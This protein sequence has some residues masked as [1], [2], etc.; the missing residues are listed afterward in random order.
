[1][2]AP[3]EPLGRKPEQPL[4]PPLGRV[5]SLHR[6]PVK[7][8]VG[9]EL[10]RVQVDERG[11][12]GDRLW[13]VRDLDG[14]FGSGKTT[15]R[16]RKMEGLLELAARY[17]AETPVV[18]FPDGRSLRG[19]DEAVHGALSEYVG[20]PV[21]LAREGGVSHFDEGPIH[22]VTT[23]TLRLLEREHGRPVQSRRLRPNLVLETADG[24]FVEEQWVDQRIRIGN[25]LVLAI[26]EPMPRCVMLDL[27][28]VG[29]PAANG[30]LKTVADLNDLNVGVVADVLTPGEVTVGDVARRESG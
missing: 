5:L 11:V 8:L 4:D 23:S 29:L 25:D 24:G 12:C 9:E 27:P 15:R 3:V 28:Q 20:R 1:V 2:T 14:R 26:R 6:Y 18:R 17:D 10:D 19:D 16:F 13:S 30:L 22:L 7:S 21:T